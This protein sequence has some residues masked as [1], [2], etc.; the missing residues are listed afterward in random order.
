MHIWRRVLPTLAAALAFQ[1]GTGGAQGSDRPTESPSLEVHEAVPEN[2]QHPPATRLQLGTFAVIL[3]ET[4]LADISD[5]IASGTISEFRESDHEHYYS[6]C[7]TVASRGEVQR[8]W[9]SSDAEFGGDEHLANNVIATVLEAGERAAAD[10]P[11]LPSRY[12]PVSLDRDVWLGLPQAAMA[13]KFP[14][15]PV[16]ASGRAEYHHVLDR[17]DIDEDYET[18]SYLTAEFRDGRVYRL[19]AS[20]ITSN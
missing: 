16:D 3:E 2:S 18:A 15:V 8:L 14:S 17:P 4:R 20:R 10:C 6:L 7:Y 13:E 5:A 9:I 11:L 12:T 1:Y 19:W